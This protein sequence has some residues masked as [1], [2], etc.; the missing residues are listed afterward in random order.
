MADRNGTKPQAPQFSIQLKPVGS[1]CNLRCSYCYVKPFRGDSSGV[2]P[3]DVLERALVSCIAGSDYPN[4]TWHGG[5]PTLAGLDFFVRA[6]YLMSRHALD[7]SVRNVLQTNATLITS[8]FAALLAEYRFEVGVSLDGPAEVHNLHRS[9]SFADVMRGVELLRQAGLDPSVICTVTADTLPF[10]EQVFD[11]L[12]ANDFRRLKYS[13][14]YDSTIDRFSISSDDWFNYLERV[15]WKWMNLGNPDLSVRE[16]DEVIAWVDREQLA[17]CSSDRT[18][19]G[20]VSV[21]PNGELYPCEYLR[22]S[23]SYGNIRSMELANIAQ[24]DTYRQFTAQFLTP[25]PQCQQCEFFAL[26]GNG[27]PATRVENDVL[28]PT[29]VYVYCEQ[30]RKLYNII[31]DVFAVDH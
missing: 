13:P 21:D 28:T 15:F 25:P 5:E 6:C 24:T 17:L 27:C 8:E 31:E 1:A 12:V 11:F 3:L 19:L 20:W 7:K 2:M 4:I 14:V 23:T 30:R 22:S 10:A 26:C 9:S 29:G 18:C 16:L